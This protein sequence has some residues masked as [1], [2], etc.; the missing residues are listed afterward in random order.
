MGANVHKLLHRTRSSQNGKVVH[1]NM[2]CH[3][4]SIANDTVV[5]YNTIVAKMNISHN[6]AV[7]SNRCFFSVNGA[8]VDGHTFSDGCV[9]TNFRGRVFTLKFL[10]PAE[11]LQSPLPGEF[12]NFTNPGTIK[13]VTLGPIHVPLLFLHLRDDCKTAYFH[14]ICNPC[15]GI[16]SRRV[17]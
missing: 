10:N 13:M 12:C 2:S 16:L 5:T 3:L 17:C 4:Y 1:F 15:I 14:I 7:G 6:Q 11:C 8:P 9:I